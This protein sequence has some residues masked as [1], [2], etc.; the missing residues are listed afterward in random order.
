MAEPATIAAGASCFTCIPN[1]QEAILYLLA[2]IAGVT[3]PA[4]IAENARCYACIPNKQEA[5]LYLLDAIATGGGGGGASDLVQRT[6]GDPEGVRT[7]STGVSIAYDP[8][9]GAVYEYT[10]AAG[11]NTGWVFK[12]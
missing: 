2:T 8:A 12:V 3:D 1:K 7:S 6:S 10:G 4:T 5:M 9:T 11:G